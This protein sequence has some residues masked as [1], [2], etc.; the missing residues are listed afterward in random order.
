MSENVKEGDP[1]GILN[2]WISRIWA[3]EDW[4]KLGSTGGLL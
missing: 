3:K 1:G 4:F 2:K